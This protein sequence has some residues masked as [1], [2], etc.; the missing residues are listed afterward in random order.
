[1]SNVL[2]KV[3]FSDNPRDGYCG[4]RECATLEEAEQAALERTSGSF[5][6]KYARIV[7]FR[8]DKDYGWCAHV[9]Y[10][11]RGRA[12]P[13]TATPQHEEPQSR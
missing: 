7:R 8:Q 10:R 6:S 2:Y 11:G 1:M 5:A 3:F 12:K 9:S 4:P 13:R